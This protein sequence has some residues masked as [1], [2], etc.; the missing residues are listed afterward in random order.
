V[1]SRADVTEIRDRW[2][3]GTGLMT[4]TYLPMPKARSNAFN[5]AWHVVGIDCYMPNHKRFDQSVDWS[6]W[7][8]P[9]VLGLCQSVSIVTLEFMSISIRSGR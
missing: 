5:V 9:T 7:S 1:E 6:T 4:S 8:L 2:Y 3:I